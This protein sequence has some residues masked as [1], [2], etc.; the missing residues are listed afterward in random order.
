[1]VYN[2]SSLTTVAGC[3]E[4]IQKAQNEITD[5]QF[6]KMDAEGRVTSDANTAQSLPAR[7]ATAEQ[8]I[9]AKEA[10]IAATT[11]SNQLSLLHIELNNLENT[12]IRL[13]RRANAL[14][15]SNV[16]IRQIGIG[17][18]EHEI[19]AWTEAVAALEA[20]KAEII[21]GDNLAA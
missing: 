19:N 16:T 3:D 6:D 8:R 13:N 2:F 4:Q 11:D 10:Q 1:M 17:L 7:I 9:T 12:L 20:R 21:A 5:L 14:S 18:M 15:G